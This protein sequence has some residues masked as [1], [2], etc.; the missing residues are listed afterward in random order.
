M[1]TDNG[2]NGYGGIGFIVLVLLFWFFSKSNEMPNGCCQ[3]MSNQC[4]SSIAQQ[5]TLNDAIRNQQEFCK[6]TSGQYEQTEKTRDKMDN[7][8][9]EYQN[10]RYLD[11]KFAT[12]KLETENAL[13]RQ[14][15]I[16]QGQFNATN[17]EIA[18][19]QCECLKR[20]PFY[21]YGCTPCP[22]TPCA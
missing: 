21:P 18:K 4:A 7:L 16:S 5:T 9:D 12:Q 2:F 20:P 15:L 19:I 10:N 6:V 22:A 17:A 3:D 11:A 13:L 14:Q 8:R 1:D